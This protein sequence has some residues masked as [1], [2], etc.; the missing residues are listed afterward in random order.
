MLLLLPWS[1]PW[2]MDKVCRNRQKGHSRQREQPELSQRND[3][4]WGVYGKLQ[5]VLIDWSVEY[6]KVGR[7]S[8]KVKAQ[9]CHSSPLSNHW[10]ILAYFFLVIFLCS[11]NFC[12]RLLIIKLRLEMQ[13]II[14]NIQI[15]LL[16]CQTL[17]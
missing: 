17:F 10:S 11:V 1:M 8:R 7:E 5:L 12:K 13:V 14:V 16:M 6:V 2:R 3:K 15:V 9:S 4:A